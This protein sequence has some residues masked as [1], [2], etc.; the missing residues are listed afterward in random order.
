MG[1]SDSLAHSLAIFQQHT[2]N[3]AHSPK[4]KSKPSASHE[5]HRKDELGTYIPTRLPEFPAVYEYFSGNK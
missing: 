3:P 1:T 2:L 4:Q 5:K